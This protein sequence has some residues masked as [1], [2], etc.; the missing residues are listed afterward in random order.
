MKM[1]F[2][3]SEEVNDSMVY[4]SF[5]IE[6]KLDDNFLEIKDFF[7][8]IVKSLCI[9]TVMSNVPFKEKLFSIFT[10]FIDNEYTTLFMVRHAVDHNYLENEEDILLNNMTYANMVDSEDYKKFRR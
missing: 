2:D 10:S 5:I 8:N 1:V 3:K 7:Y 6:T 9:N 4:K